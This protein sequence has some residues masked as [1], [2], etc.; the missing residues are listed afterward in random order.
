[1]IEDLTEE[2]KDKA[3]ESLSFLNEKRDC[4]MKARTCANGSAQRSYVPKEEAA[5]PTVSTQSVLITGV[6]DAK[7]G[8]DV[9]IIDM[10]N[11]FVQTVLPDNDEKVIM[12]I[13][14]RLVHALVEIDPDKYSSHA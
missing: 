7:Q 13:R 2:K 5:I 14:G 10:P 1:M 12:K 4:T 6:I 3:M 8:R 9:M 11:A